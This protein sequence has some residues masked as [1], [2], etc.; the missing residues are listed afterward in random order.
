MFSIFIALGSNINPEDGM[1]AAAIMLR[2]KYPDIRFSSVYKTKALDAEDQPDFLN[3]VAA[4]KSAESAATI[5]NGLME[6]ERALKKNPPFP[7]GPRTID[8]DLLLR[9]DELISVAGLEVPHPRMH[10]RRFVLEPLMELLSPAAKHPATGK[11]WEELLVGVS[12]QYAQKTGMQ[13]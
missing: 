1:Q 11:T 4:F 8:L 5:L 6:I 10:E 3:A 12:G 7:K 2:N 13:L 9:G